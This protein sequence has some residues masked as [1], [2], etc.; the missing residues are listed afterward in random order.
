MVNYIGEVAILCTKIRLYVIVYDKYGH[1]IEMM[2]IYRNMVYKDCGYYTQCLN[3]VIWS[4]DIQHTYCRIQ[5]KS[6]HA[7]RNFLFVTL[8]WKLWH[9]QNFVSCSCW[10]VHFGAVWCQIH[11]GGTLLEPKLAIYWQKTE[12]WARIAI[13]GWL[14]QFGPFV[15]T[16]SWPVTTTIFRHV[17]LRD[18]WLTNWFE[19]YSISFWALQHRGI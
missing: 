10:V 18:A 16:P 1:C 5:F 11:S 7:W 13:F 15:S 12:F 2:L 17:T 4:C 14:S 6:T 8:L 9:S 19:F 3:T